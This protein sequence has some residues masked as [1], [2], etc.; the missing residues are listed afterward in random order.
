MGSVGV[1]FLNSCLGLGT[2][3]VRWSCIKERSFSDAALL[4]GIEVLVWM[5]EFMPLLPRGTHESL[6]PS[7]LAVMDNWGLI[8]LEMLGEDTQMTLSPDFRVGLHLWERDGFVDL[9]VVLE[10]L[11]G[12]SCSSRPSLIG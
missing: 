5:H 10:A 1:P 7:L 8:T 3:K 9:T 6:R 11:C 12:F 4:R 2:L